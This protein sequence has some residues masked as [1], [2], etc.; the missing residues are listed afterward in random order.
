MTMGS[1]AWEREDPLLDGLPDGALERPVS[2]VKF[3]EVLLERSTAVLRQRRRRGRAL[4]A[5]GWLVAY[6][7][8]LATA[9]L[10]LG[11]EQAPPVAPLDRVAQ[12]VAP[13]VDQPS[14]DAA[15]PD[16][17][18]WELERRS[19][20]AEEAQRPELLRLAGD[21][22]FNDYA[23]V[24]SALRCY[25]QLLDLVPS[26]QRTFDPSDNYLL[27]SLK[28]ARRSETPHANTGT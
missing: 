11:S 23:D 10:A 15:L 14:D 27:T 20:S 22:Y 1:E 21:R 8:G 26:D 17:P 24:Q 12:G 6:A 7:A 28:Q 18:P 25:R 16:L 2:S 3:R 4:S 9:F 5:A 13:A 19:A